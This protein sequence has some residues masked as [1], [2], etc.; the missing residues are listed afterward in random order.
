M[1]TTERIAKSA[2]TP[3]TGFF[4]TLRGLLGAK[5]SG[6]PS[7]A[8]A[9]GSAALSQTSPPLGTSG[10][11]NGRR[12]PNRRA[13]GRFSIAW[14]RDQHAGAAQRGGSGFSL[15]RTSGSEHP[16]AHPRPYAALGT[17][18]YRR[19]ATLLVSISVLAS[20]GGLIAASPAAAEGECTT[21][22]PW[23]HLL[24][25][26]Q[27]S[28]LP[29]GGEGVLLTSAV[30]VGEVATTGD[31]TLV[32]R[33]PANL[34]VVASTVIARSGDGPQSVV[35][36][37][38]FSV[39]TPTTADPFTEEDGECHLE[40]AV[41][42]QVA[43]CTFH[44]GVEHIGLPFDILE[45]RVGVRARAGAH[46]GEM[47]RVSMSG[48][49]A[50]SVAIERPLTFAAP[51]D[52][53]P[54]GIATNEITLEEQG[55]TTD[56]RAG[57]HPFQTTFT[58]TL[59]ETPATNNP[60][61]GEP[62]A[63]PVQ[64]PRD[65]YFK[66]PPG[67]IGNP[68][69]PARCTQ[70]ELDSEP[71]GCPAAS[72]VGVAVT[73]FTEPGITGVQTKVV[74][75]FNLEPSRG[76]AARFGFLPLNKQTPVYI[77]ASIRTGSDYGVTGEVRNIPQ[78]VEFVKSVVSLWGVPGS[79]LHNETRDGCLALVRAR[80]NEYP[81]CEPSSASN[82]PPFFE[83]P[84]ACTG[85]LQTTSEVDSWEK[86]GSFVTSNGTGLPAIDGCNHLPFNPSIKVK[87]DVE[88]ASS[89]SGLEV[90]VHIPQEAS[91]NANG[92]GES[93]PRNITVTLPEGVAV[94]PSGG[95]GLQA[96]SEGLVG[97]TGL[98]ELEDVP[99][100]SALF[101]PKLPNP[102]EPG[103]NFCPDSSKIGTAV[104]KTPLLE[105][106]IEGDVYLATQNQNPFGSLIAM[107][108]VAEDPI[109][110]VLIKLTGQVHLNPATGQLVTTFENS[111]QAPFE[112]AIL[113]FF[114]GERAPLST[115]SHCGTYTTTAQFTSWSDEP[116]E[117]PHDA[118]STFN[119]TSGP[120]GSP[121]PGSSLPFSPS[122]TGGTTNINAGSF[123]PLVTTIGREDGQQDMQQV[124]LHM[125][126]GPRGP[127]S[128]V[129]LCP[130]A[131]ANEGSCGPESLIGE[132]IVS[133]GVGSDPVSVTGGKVY[134]TEKY[135][136]APFGL[137][138]VNPVKAGP[139]DLERDTSNPA[140]NPPCD[141]VVVRAKI[142]VNPTT[143]ELTVTTDPSGPH[144][145]PH[146]ID[147]IPVQIKR[148]NVTVNREHFTFNPTSCN[149]TALTGSIGSDEGASSPL[150][151]PFQATNCAVLKYTPQFTTTTA[152]KASKNNGASLTFRIAYPKGAM[153][154]QSWFNY[155]KFDIPAQLPARLT[156][157]QKA[158]LAATFETNRGACPAASVIGHAIVHTQVLPVPLEGP[159]YFVSYGNAKFPDAVL[160][161]KGY[162]I[163]IELH[164]HTFIGGKTEVTSA[165]FENLPDVPFENI[166][167]TVPQGPFS[168]FGANLPAKA[169][170]S[171]CGQKLVMPV[172]FKASNG[173]EIAQNTPVGVTGCPKAKSRAQLY[174]AAL[175]ACH[176]IKKKGKRKECEATA[177][178]R[179]GPP[180]KK[181]K[182][183]GRGNK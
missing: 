66:L 16:P 27:P 79:V 9:D 171:F 3:K 154:S 87:P 135:A 150:S 5:G 125:P 18:F 1:R 127:P 149:P 133:A 105:H 95:D 58:F 30:N 174:A 136:G 112:D 119:I 102:L 101:T 25:G 120:N 108:I 145:I 175:K 65:A 23:W 82:P 147:G 110:G 170:N 6:A 153:G 72:A 165:T 173:L 69:A 122:L 159:V 157:L 172:R 140:Q 83:L 59:N 47:N 182:K 11:S 124:Q 168:E 163:T 22:R 10:H 20:A 131:Q 84:T 74:P 19:L 181:A 21:C 53:T 113:H 15:H 38:P 152:S 176:K 33:V 167:V 116:G 8:L 146:L 177:R 106:P 56:T 13:G 49:G 86:P 143:A 52:K 142:E 130:E 4:A 139:F 137:S 126:A 28:D 12:V 161:L 46:S 114:G 138:I 42:S 160:V 162:G 93:D 151:V 117:A 183:S 91:L 81:P 68:Q 156:T 17:G 71:I 63:H 141:C 50:P 57:S 104:I 32:D 76:E 61:N 35:G 178:R 121:C 70:A 109:S 31:V 55:G 51:G 166:E 107:Y 54:F 97:F 89:S 24:S 88:S 180:A 94:N 132:T 34:E 148:V 44:S 41:G 26:T 73:G 128:G 75:V 96:C 40:G 39:N 77:S 111:P 123:S 179:Y 98:G 115:P 64:L 118:S 85:Q 169:N 80:G 29:E 67:L 158:C 7:S 134:I 14:R 45:V 99:D 92:L 129:K 37:W 62:E 36:A 90:D 48:G 103:S 100:T 2:S 144:A 60:R 164:G 43:S 155:A 78:T